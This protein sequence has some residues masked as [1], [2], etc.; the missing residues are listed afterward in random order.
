MHHGVSIEE[1]ERNLKTES[2]DTHPE[3]ENIQVE[4]LRRMTV[5]QR[6]GLGRALTALALGSA[7]RAIQEANPTAGEDDIALIFVARNYQAELA[8]GLRTH[9]EQEKRHMSLGDDILQALEP[10]VA[11]LEELGVSYYIGGSL[12]SMAWGKPRTTLDADVV[13]YLRAEHVKPL[14][15]LIGEEYYTS[16][17]M[18]QDAILRMS[19]FNVISYK[20]SL[21]ID[22]FIPSQDEFD[23][24]E[25][26][27]ISQRPL[28]PGKG[29]RLYN[30]SSPED[31]VLRKIDWYKAGGGISDRQWDDILNVLKNRADT[32]DRPYMAEWAANLGISDLLDRAIGD[33]G[34]PPMEDSRS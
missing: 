8:R 18:I 10:F 5:A 23:K 24:V 29:S 25:L 1:A 11:A 32:L 17:E 34:L 20:T 27:R 31:I 15:S 28:G 4:I 6:V 30:V 12:A 21:K 7:R 13:A 26:T 16:E 2:R 19:S 33:A 22:V 14:L 9:I 3:M